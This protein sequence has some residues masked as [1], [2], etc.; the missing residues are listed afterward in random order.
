MLDNLREWQNIQTYLTIRKYKLSEYDNSDD[1]EWD[2][3]I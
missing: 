3:D 1:G 2:G